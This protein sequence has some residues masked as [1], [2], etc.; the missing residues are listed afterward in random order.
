MVAGGR[1]EIF[2]EL[3]ARYQMPVFRLAFSI[4]GSRDDAQDAAQDVFIRAYKSLKTYSESG[5]FWPWLRRITVNVCLKKIRPVLISLDDL[6]EMPG[7]DKDSVSESVI[8][9]MESAQLR[10]V[11]RELPPAYRSVVVLKYL[12]DMNYSEIAEILGETVTNVGVRIH[13]AKEMLRERM[14]VTCDEMQRI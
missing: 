1:Q 14:K 13:R 4:L 5:N 10:R 2:G 6:S 11:I 12:E 8:G 3:V 7:S 9:A